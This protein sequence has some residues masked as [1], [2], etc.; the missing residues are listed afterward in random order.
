MDSNLSL[1][2]IAAVTKDRDGFL[3]DGGGGWFL[4]II[5]LFLVGGNGFWGNRAGSA[6]VEDFATQR[7]VL[8]SAA[9]TQ[10]DVLTSGCNSQKD[11]L[12]SRYTTQLGLQN[13]GSQMAACCCDLKTAIVNEGAATRQL[14]T[15][16]TI[17]DLREKLNSANS[18]IVNANQTQYILGQLGRYVPS[19][20]LSYNGYAYNGYSYPYYTG[21]GTGTVI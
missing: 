17:N 12:E 10:R 9:Q 6:T 1:A 18:A 19:S 11:I 7:E 2:D 16:N 8:N 3:G 14:I 4:I 20:V 21:A 5:L 15:D 13:L